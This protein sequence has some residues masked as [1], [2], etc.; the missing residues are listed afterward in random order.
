MR[1]R[2]R[3]GGAG[4]SWLDTEVGVEPRVG[5]M[6]MFEA[7]QD[8]HRKISSCC[9]TPTLSLTRAGERSIRRIILAAWAGRVFDVE[10]R[11]VV[12][13]VLGKR[14]YFDVRFGIVVSAKGLTRGLGIFG[15]LRV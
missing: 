8:I 13:L 4:E 3:K 5:L 2:T 11:S 7:G 15:A 12:P 1:V 10:V 9:L 6:K 14:R